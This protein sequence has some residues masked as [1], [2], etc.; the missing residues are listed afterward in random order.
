[1]TEQKA[2]AAI[3]D[4]LTFVMASQVKDE[5]MTCG[6]YCLR[7]EELSLKKAIAAEAV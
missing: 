1:M 6:N 5:Q 3:A 4:V 7:A 2:G